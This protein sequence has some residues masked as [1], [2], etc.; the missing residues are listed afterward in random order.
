MSGIQFNRLIIKNFLAFGSQP[1]AINLKGDRITVVLGLNHDTG[2]GESRNGAGKSS[3]IDALSY[4]LYG[5]T[6][7]DVGNNKLVNKLMRKGQGMS[8]VLEMDTPTGLYRIE[9]GEAPAKLK[10]Y[11]KELDNTNDFLERDGKTFIYDISRSTKGETTEMIEE[12]IG[13]DIKLFEF[14][15][16]NSSEST[17]FMKLPEA[18][19]R[20]IAERLMG[21]NMLTERAEELKEERKHKK[22]ELVSVDSAITATEQANDRINRQVSDLQSRE[23]QWDTQKQN[24]LRDLQKQIDNL[25]GVD[26]KEQIELLEIVE[27]IQVEETRIA[28]DRRAVNMELSQAKRD[29]SDITRDITTKTTRNEKLVGQK[30]QLDKSVCPTCEQHWVADPTV[31]ENLADEIEVISAFL[32]ES[33][34]TVT[35]AEAQIDLVTSKLEV[36][37]EED[38]ELANT[39]TYLGDFDLVFDSIVDANAAGHV[40]DT[41]KAKLEEVEASENPHTETIVALQADALKDID[42]AESVELMKLIQHYNYLIDLLQSKNSFLR[43]AVIDRWLPKLNGRIAHHLGVLNL[44][45]RVRLTNELDMEITKLDDVY[46]FGNLSKGQRQRVTIAL[47]LAFQDLFEATNHPLSLLLVDELIDNGIDTSGAEQALHALQETCNSKGKRV[48][49]ITHRHDIS[50]NV[51]SSG[52]DVMTIELKNGISTITDDEYDEC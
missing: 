13:F 24:S 23:R 40:I 18:K 22:T 48:F 12:L 45:F 1:T 35:A 6:I 50:D 19:K 37:D 29:L 36:V 28:A 26:V 5:K 17:P 8:V 42:R 3:I 34:T 25:I 20:E 41:N 15:I 39:L 47:N 52:G 21:L 33:T 14:L 43:K 38:N 10:L 7:R 2:G 4:V 46:D 27:T 44:P 31:I 51:L 11:R 16:A 49:L 32:T 9:R 30:E